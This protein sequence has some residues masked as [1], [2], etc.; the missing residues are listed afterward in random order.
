MTYEIDQSGKIEQTSIDTV[1]AITNSNQYALIFNKTNKR[2]LVFSILIAL[3]IKKAGIKHKVIIDNEYLGHEKFIAERI[4]KTLED[5]K[6]NNLPSI[7]FGHIGKTS[8]AHNLA[9]KVGNRKIKADMN[10][11]LEEIGALLLKSKNRL[12]TA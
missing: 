1:I 6:I 3:I 9:R 5:L 8:K 11:R 10:I 4:N 7:Q 12:K 2:R